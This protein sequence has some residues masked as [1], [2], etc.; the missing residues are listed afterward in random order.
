M[1]FE[2]GQERAG[3]AGFAEASAAQEGAAEVGPRILCPRRR[4]IAP[5]LLR[6]TIRRPFSEPFLCQRSSLSVAELATLAGRE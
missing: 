1:H 4:S 3:V 6:G 2:F 5:P